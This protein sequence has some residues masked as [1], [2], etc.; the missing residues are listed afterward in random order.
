MFVALIHEIPGDLFYFI[1]HTS[2]RQLPYHRFNL[3]VREVPSVLQKVDTL[4]PGLDQDQRLFSFPQ[5]RSPV[6]A[7]LFRSDEKIDKVILD[8]EGY[9]GIQAEQV[10]GFCL[11]CRSSGE[12][13]TNAGGRSIENPGLFLHHF[14]I[15]VLINVI[16]VRKRHVHMLPQADIGTCTGKHGYGTHFCII[17]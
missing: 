7:A 1:D 17:S 6:F 13:C 3:C 14:K 9:P 11:G 4:F 12:N 16:P 15:F 8:L 2:I 5:I 10:E